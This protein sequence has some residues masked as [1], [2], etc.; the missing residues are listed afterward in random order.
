MMNTITNERV[1]P[2]KHVDKK[3]ANSWKQK[4]RNDLN[5]TQYLSKK[6]TSGNQSR[7]KQPNSNT[8]GSMIKSPSQKGIVAAQVA[9]AT[10]KSN[11]NSDQNRASK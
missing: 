5:K 9:D 11:M 7:S 10:N 8:S 2:K 4:T 6:S 3:D 1:T